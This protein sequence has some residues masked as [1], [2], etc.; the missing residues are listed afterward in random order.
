MRVPLN[1]LRTA[2]SLSVRIEGYKRSLLAKLRNALNRVR[3]ETNVRRE[4]IR[5][6]FKVSTTRLKIVFLTWWYR[7]RLPAFWVSC[8]LVG[9]GLVLV[10]VRRWSALDAH[11]SSLEKSIIPEMAIGI[12]AAITGIIAI[13][14][15]L[16]LF[17]IQQ[18][19]DRG[20]PATVQAYAR[21]SVM[22]LIYWALAV[23]ATTCFATA[24]FKADTTYRAVAVTV[25]L[26]SL[27]LSFILLNCHFKRVVKFSDPRYT[28]SRI[29][30]RGE[31]Q[32]KTLQKLRES[33]VPKSQS[34]TGK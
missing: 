31:K 19:A 34:E 18:V 12:G 17:A 33:I 15:S 20:T 22:R 10:L 32:L 5:R 25:G 7:Y 23:L 27:F 29:Y 26:A 9:F 16:S 14:F 11:L 3:L 24:L 8:A 4:L 30:S 2:N 13:A 28:V 21:D 1:K 6:G